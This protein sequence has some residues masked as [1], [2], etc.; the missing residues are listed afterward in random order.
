MMSDMKEFWDEF[1]NAG[2]TKGTKIMIQRIRNKQFVFLWERGGKQFLRNWERWGKNS[3]WK[4]PD[5]LAW[6]KR[7]QTNGSSQ[8]SCEQDFL[9]CVAIDEE[10]VKELIK[11]KGEL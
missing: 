8:F 10:R 9:D 11:R 7:R 4:Y 1:E 3:K 2:I 6:A 5:W